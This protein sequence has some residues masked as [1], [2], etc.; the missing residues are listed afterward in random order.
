MESMGSRIVKCEARISELKDN[1]AFNEQLLK[2][3]LKAVWK[4]DAITSGWYKE[5]ELITIGISE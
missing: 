5:N 2:G 3:I 4:M 1:D